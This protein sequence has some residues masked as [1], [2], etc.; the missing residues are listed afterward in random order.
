MKKLRKIFIIIFSFIAFLSLAEIV[1]CNSLPD[2]GRKIEK[3]EKEIKA[4]EEENQELHLEIATQ[5]SLLNI[6]QQAEAKGFQKPL[7]VYIKGQSE[8]AFEP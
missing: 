6:A 3:I 2:K 8:I 4:L 5:G 1:L 7:V